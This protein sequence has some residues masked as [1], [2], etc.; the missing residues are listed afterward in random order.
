VPPHV[1]AILARRVVAEAGPRIALGPRACRQTEPRRATAGAS[2]GPQ[3]C[4]GMGRR[5]R[6]DRHS[7]TKT[8]PPST[9]TG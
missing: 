1:S 2:A 3:R 5:S 8:R 9:F 7:S 4:N 6:Q